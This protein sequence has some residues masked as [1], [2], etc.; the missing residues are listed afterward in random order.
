METFLGLILFLVVAGCIA[1]F[2]FIKPRMD[3]GK[4]A[5]VVA[6]IIQ[7]KKNSEKGM[8]LGAGNPTAAGPRPLWKFSHEGPFYGDNFEVIIGK[9]APF[10]VTD[11]AKRQEMERG[12]LFKPQSDVLPKGCTIHDEGGSTETVCEIRW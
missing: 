12:R 6:P 9:L 10:I 7:E 4:E 3:K 8:Y 2:V 11:C 1:Y 5:V